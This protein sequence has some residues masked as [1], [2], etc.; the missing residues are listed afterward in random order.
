MR[1]VEKWAEIA[2]LVCL[3]WFSLMIL[4]ACTV[5]LYRDIAPG[6]CQ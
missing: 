5:A 6:V 4:I 3:G 2:A 1:L